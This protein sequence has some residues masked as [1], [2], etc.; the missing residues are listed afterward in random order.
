MSKTCR[1]WPKGLWKIHMGT[2]VLGHMLFLI[3]ERTFSTA[4]IN[5]DTQ[6][7]FLEPWYC[8]N[9]MHRIT[10]AAKQITQHRHLVDKDELWYE[11]VTQERG[12]TEAIA[13]LTNGGGAAF[14]DVE[15][16]KSLKLKDLFSDDLDKENN[17]DATCQ[18]LEPDSLLHDSFIYEVQNAI[19]ERQNE[20]E[21][22]TIM[23]I[24]PLPMTRTTRI[25]MSR[26]AIKGLRRAS[27]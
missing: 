15:K 5:S 27:E 19:E 23:N 16:I 20:L 24:F 4:V 11:E 2:C 8:Q 18:P 17:E 13:D 25:S 14:L 22:R 6:L 26:N 12:E 1:C 10:W 3:K 9:D 21:H 7:G